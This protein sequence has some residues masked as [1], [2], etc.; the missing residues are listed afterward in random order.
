M[1]E[2]DSSKNIEFHIEAR[3]EMVFSAEWYEDQQ[4]GVGD[5]FLD[6]VEAKLGKISQKPESYSKVYKD[7]RKAS[8]KFPFS[9]FYIIKTPVI[10]I[11]AVWHKK[12][13]PDGWKDRIE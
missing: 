9:I 1:Q 6:E 5:K 4:S 10:F 7:V 3:E 11:L 8:L 13:H 12:R 2:N